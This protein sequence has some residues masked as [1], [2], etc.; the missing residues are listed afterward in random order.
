MAERFEGQLIAGEARFALAV[1]RFNELATRRL[2]EGALDA[3]RRHGGD[4]DTATVAWVPGSFELPVTAQRLAQSGRFDAVLGLG[5]VI[6]GGT[7]HFDH[8]VRGAT[9][10][11]QQVAVR[12]GVPVMLGVIT[13]ESLEQAL[14]RAGGKEGNQGERAMRSAIETANLFRQ[15]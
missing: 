11:L 5:C 14:E 6:Q 12:T 10:G 13:A 8:V 2:V 4:P 3:L 7:R 9:D 15:L 1:A